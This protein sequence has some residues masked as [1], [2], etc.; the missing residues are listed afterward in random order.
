MRCVMMARLGV[1]VAGAL[2]SAGCCCLL[3]TSNE[4]IVEVELC[5]H[6]LPNPDGSYPW[7]GMCLLRRDA[8]RF[9]GA[10]VQENHIRG[11]DFE[12][13]YTYTVRASKQRQTFLG[14]HMQTTFHMEELLERRSAAGQAFT[15]EKMGAP[16]LAAGDKP[17][18]LLDGE[19]FVCAPGACEALD[20][21]V[22][23]GAAERFTMRFVHEAEGKR[24]RLRLEAVE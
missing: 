6:K 2:M 15:L 16:W 23:R 4:G 11:L 9:D 3:P 22:A 12:W 21:R 19:A 14:S 5:A 10:L 8:E 18:A 1:M 7:L 17:R 24:P 13:G 20:E